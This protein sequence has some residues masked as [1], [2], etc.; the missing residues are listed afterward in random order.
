MERVIHQF[1]REEYHAVESPIEQS[2]ETLTHKTLGGDH[3]LVVPYH[4]GAAEQTQRAQKD[5]ELESPVMGGIHG[6]ETLA[7]G[8]YEPCVAEHHAPSGQTG[9]RA[10][11][12]Y[13][14]AVCL[15]SGGSVKEMCRK[16]SRLHP[17]ADVCDVLSVIEIYLHAC[18]LYAGECCY[19]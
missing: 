12:D 6:V 15:Q 16:L 2:A 13:A 19:I 4:H 1:L 18:C 10:V 11:P 14:Y 3:G 7:R 5:Y 8:E 17:S 9:A